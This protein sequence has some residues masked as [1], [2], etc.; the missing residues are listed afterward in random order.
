MDKIA[1]RNWGLVRAAA[2]NGGRLSDDMTQR[3]LRGWKG[4]PSQPLPP[5]VAAKNLGR[6]VYNKALLNAPR[7]ATG[8]DFAANYGD[9]V[10]RAGQQLGGAFQNFAHA[11]GQHALATLGLG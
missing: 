3:V 8:I 5:V 1:L 9:D 7:I 10:M 11:G 6:T 2:Q 4:V